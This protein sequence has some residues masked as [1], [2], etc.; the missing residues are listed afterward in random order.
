MFIDKNDRVVSLAL[1]LNGVWE[2]F[3]TEVFK[4][5]LKRGDVVLDIGANIGY[6]TLIAAEIVG[7]NGHVYAF[8]P[9]S[10][11]FGVLKRNVEVNGYKNVILV[12]KALSDKNGVGKLFL[13]TEDN[14]G[15]FRI[16]GSNDDRKSVDIELVRLDSF[17][18]N[19]I[20]KINVIKIDVQGAEALIFKGASKTLKAIKKIK[21]F[22]EFWPKA[23]RLSGSSAEEYSHILMKNR[24][25]IYEIDSSEKRMAEVSFQKLFEKYPEDSLYNADLFC[26]KK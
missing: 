18:G 15:D 9:D 24:F 22:T 8:E 16:F 2:E 5:N 26:V 6:H 4:K 25:K 7:N 12:N 23:L 13:S 10:K 3:E 17:F 11:N 1:I 20:P 14:H 21:V 19:H